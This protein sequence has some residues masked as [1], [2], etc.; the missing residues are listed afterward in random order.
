[1]RV[2]VQAAAFFELCDDDVL[3]PDIAVKQLEWIVWELG[4]LDPREREALVAFVLRE[5]EATNDSR[6]RAFLL[7]FPD[8]FG[9]RDEE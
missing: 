1:M 5:A 3:D 6:Y 9:L 7:S 2:V 8:V 4:K